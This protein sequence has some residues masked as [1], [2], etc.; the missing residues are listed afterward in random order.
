LSGKPAIKVL[1]YIWIPL[2]LAGSIALFILGLFAF[3]ETNCLDL[4]GKDQCQHVLFIGNSYTYVNDLPGMFVRL[5]RSGGHAVQV[6]MRAEGG[7]SLADHVGSA[8][9][10]EKIRSRQ[11]DIVVLQEQSQIPASPE[12]RTSTMYP[13]ARKLIQEITANDSRPVLFLTWAHKEGWP[14]NNLSGYDA[15]QGQIDQGYLRLA[16]EANAMVIP[17]GMAWSK[18]FHQYPDLSLWQDD[19]SHP[20]SQGTYLAACVFYAALFHQSPS[21]LSYHADI[22]A[23]TARVLQNIAGDIVLTNPA[24]WNIQ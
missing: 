7:W 15:M 23:D 12:A 5:S 20:T 2:A 10:G 17:V 16:G 4:S 13:S 6:D 1:P 14:E 11:W 18:A 3:L 22:P 21:G 8:V 19:G 24:R 9:T